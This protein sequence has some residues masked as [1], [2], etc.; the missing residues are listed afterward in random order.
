[1]N[2]DRF[3]VFDNVNN[4][5]DIG[6]LALPNGR[7]MKTGILFRSGDLSRATAADAE[8]LRRLNIRMICDLRTP[9]ERIF[10]R[11][12]ILQDKSVRLVYVPIHHRKG[13]ANQRARAL[14]WKKLHGY[15]FTR[16]IREYYLTLAFERTAQINE[17]FTLLSDTNN[18]PALIHCVAGKD[19][20]GFVAALI[21]SVAG[22]PRKAVIEDYLQTNRFYQPQ[23]LKFVQIVRWLTMFYASAESIQQLVEVHAEYLDETLHEIVT[24]YETIEEYLAKA[25]GINESSLQHLK[26]QLA[27]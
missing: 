22:A 23:I 6:G 27:G 21:Q 2:N 18:L 10:R 25:C 8:T 11:D 1:M 24:R 5:R 12:R 9:R 7:M 20:T 26:K 17:L 14:L 15:D 16:F 4:F 13:S 19:R 3:I